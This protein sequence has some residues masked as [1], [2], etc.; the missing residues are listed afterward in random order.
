MGGNRSRAYHA[1]EQCVRRF[2]ER[3]DA[4]IELS[5]AGRA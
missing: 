1:G 2:A 4:L 5:K 3:S